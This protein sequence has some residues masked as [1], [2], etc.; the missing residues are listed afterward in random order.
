MRFCVFFINLCFFIFREIRYLN[1]VNNNFQRQITALT[2]DATFKDAEVRRLKDIVL[3]LEKTTVRQ[4][5]ANGD[6]QALNKHFETKI[7]ELETKNAELETSNAQLKKLNKDLKGR[8][9][10]LHRQLHLVQV[11]NELQNDQIARLTRK[12]RQSEGSLN[13]A[14]A[15]LKTV[16][17][18]LENTELERLRFSEKLS[19]SRVD[20]DKKKW[21][22]RKLRLLEK[23]RRAFVKHD[24]EFEQIKEDNEKKYGIIAGGAIKRGILFGKYIANARNI[25]FGNYNAPTIADVTAISNMEFDELYSELQR[26]QDVAVAAPHLNELMNE[27]YRLEKLKDKNAQQC[28]EQ[29]KKFTEEAEKAM[30]IKKQRQRAKQLKK[31]EKKKEA[32]ALDSEGASDDSE[33]ASDGAAS[34]ESDVETDLEDDDSL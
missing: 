17:Q 30:A 31:E 34:R 6:L 14:L 3:D 7:A 28:K 19:L 15:D 4:R 5:G 8:A 1:A 9:S 13:R 12:S 23:Y 11:D 22:D 29:L 21:K 32:A 16:Q 27:F 18:R 25:D 2:R 20:F 26:V 10:E 33:G 24:R